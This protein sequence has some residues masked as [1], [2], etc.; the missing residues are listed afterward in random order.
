L[1]LLVQKEQTKSVIIQV[2]SYFYWYAHISAQVLDFWFTDMTSLSSTFFLGSSKW[3]K[4]PVVTLDDDRR[5][6]YD[7]HYSRNS[8]MFAALDDE[9]KLLVPVSILRSD[10]V[11]CQEFTNLNFGWLVNPA[12]LTIVDHYNYC[13][14]W[15]CFNLS[16]VPYWNLLC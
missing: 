11:C 15:N 3:G 16:L 2:S 8:S 1:V 9:R 4:K 6:T 14:K 10:T 7:Q 12:N 5:S 13:L